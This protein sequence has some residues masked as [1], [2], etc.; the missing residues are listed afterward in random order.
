[1]WEKINK[2][3][4]LGPSS[5]SLMVFVIALISDGCGNVKSM[6]EG[7]KNI[8]A[9]EPVN[10]EEANT[11]YI[12]FISFQN[13]DSTWGF[14]IFVN[15]R[16][17]VHHKKIPVKKATSG[18]VSQKDAEAVAAIFVKMIHNGNLKPSIDP[19]ALDTLGIVIRKG[20]M[21]G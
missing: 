14:T 9:A 13:P 16:P 2:N 20:K 15:S 10:L 3:N 6:E 12:K 5:V 1:M 8:K 4:W 7:N 17:F 19:V 11:A 21:P 18:F